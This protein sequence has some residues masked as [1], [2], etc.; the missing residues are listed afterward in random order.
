M[1]T[2]N[3]IK[4]KASA[5]RD[6]LALLFTPVV[7]MLLIW[8]ICVLAYGSWTNNVETIRLHYLG[9]VCIILASLVGLGGQWFQR[10]RVAN[11]KVAAFGATVDLSQQDV[12]GNGAAN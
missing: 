5:A 7:T 1:L 12:N 2:P 4:A 8:L 10:Q 9:A 3:S 11:L 6:I